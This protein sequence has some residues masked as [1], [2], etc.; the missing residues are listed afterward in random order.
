MPSIGNDFILT[1]ADA[2][3][4]AHLYHDNTNNIGMDPLDLLTGGGHEVPGWLSCAD[5][6]GSSLVAPRMDAVGNLDPG[7]VRRANMGLFKV[8]T[9]PCAK[10]ITGR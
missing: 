9:S 8:G 2:P 3:S 1:T 10:R 4:H 5:N 6:G 7:E